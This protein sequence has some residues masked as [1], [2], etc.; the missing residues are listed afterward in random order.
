ML[1]W[2]KRCFPTSTESRKL[3]R[4]EAAGE[5]PGRFSF[6]SE[7]SRGSMKRTLLLFT[8][9]AVTGCS[10]S[11][12][13]VSTSSA[14]S[15]TTYETS[16]TMTPPAPTTQAPLLPPMETSRGPLASPPSGAPLATPPAA[17]TATAAA[18]QQPAIDP[19][20]APRIHPEELRQRMASGRIVLLDVRPESVFREDG[21]PGAINIPLDQLATRVGELP[22]DKY[23]ATYCT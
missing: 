16:T 17:P 20:K 23:I 5:E 8:I 14:E 1:P 11:A 12:T 22:R 21:V 19:S 3:L 2:R 10:E 18:S 7:G 13:S 6:Q 9:V 4:F 15:T